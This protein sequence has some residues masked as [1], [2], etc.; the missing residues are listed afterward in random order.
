MAPYFHSHNGGFDSSENLG[1]T[2]DL[3]LLSGHN[4]AANHTADEHP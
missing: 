4:I 1:R 2:Q 3:D